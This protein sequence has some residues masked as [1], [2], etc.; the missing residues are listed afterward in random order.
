MNI[1]NELIQG[2]EDLFANHIN[3]Y[4]L[5]NLL[6]SIMLLLPLHFQMQ[7]LCIHKKDAILLAKNKFPKEALELVTWA[8]KIR[9]VWP[10]IQGYSHYPFLRFFNRICGN[11]NLTE[12]LGAK[13]LPNIPLDTLPTITRND[14]ESFISH[15]KKIPQ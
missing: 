7:G 5:K 12:L 10:S 4:S 13:F 2:K 1:L 6:S 15:I 3:L 11:R 9:D 14:F 8:T